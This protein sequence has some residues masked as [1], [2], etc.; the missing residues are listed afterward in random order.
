MT[1]QPPTPRL[2]LTAP[3]DLLRDGPGPRLLDVRG[4]ERQVRLVAAVLT[5]TC[6]RGMPPSKL[7]CNTGPGTGIDQGTP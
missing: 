7:S 3:R 2:D 1:T 5:N 4:L 6:A